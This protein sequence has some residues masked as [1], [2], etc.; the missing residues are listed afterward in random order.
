MANPE[1]RLQA[2]GLTL[3]AAAA[4]IASYVP[5]VRTGNVLYVSGQIPKHADGKRASPPRGSLGFL[6][7]RHP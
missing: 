4:P 3:P 2:K 5:T 7:L 1:A 6:H